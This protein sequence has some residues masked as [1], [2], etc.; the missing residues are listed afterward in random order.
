MSRAIDLL[1]GSNVGSTTKLGEFELA[2]AML[3]LGHQLHTWHQSLSRSLCLIEADDLANSVRA[4]GLLLRLRIILTL[5]YHNVFLLINRPILDHCISKLVDEVASNRDR[6]RNT[7]STLESLPNLSNILSSTKSIIDIV[8]F[9]VSKNAEHNYKGF[10][11][12]WW[13]SLYY[14][15]L[16]RST[17][18]ET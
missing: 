10:L 7:H 14:S 8:G 4:G 1:Y 3:D 11:G 13:F 16:A 5:R 17:S 9:L 2:S 12:A 15:K 18:C 6:E